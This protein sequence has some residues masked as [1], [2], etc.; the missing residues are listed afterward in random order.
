MKNYFRTKK[1]V[2]VN[3]KRSQ[4]KD[5]LI[6][7]NLMSREVQVEIRIEGNL[8]DLLVLNSRGIKFYNLQFLSLPRFINITVK[9][10]EEDI[11]LTLNKNR[12]YK[13]FVF[14]KNLINKLTQSL[15]S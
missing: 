4:Q 3:S 10:V 6:I 8:L 7:K 11:D 13:R 2:Y 12:Y 5:F 14:L 15:S 9:E 1:Y